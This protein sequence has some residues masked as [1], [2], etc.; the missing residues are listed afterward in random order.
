MGNLNVKLIVYPNCKLSA[1]DDSSYTDLPDKYGTIFK[2]IADYVSLE[3]L[4]Y[5]DSK[6]IEPNTIIF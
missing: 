6:E 3:F 5:S 4:T 1:I 2:S